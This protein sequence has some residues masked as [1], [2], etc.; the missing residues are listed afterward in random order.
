MLRVLVKRGVNLN[1][2]DNHGEAALSLMSSAGHLLGVKTLLDSTVDVNAGFPLHKALENIVN[3][4][5][6]SSQLFAYKQIALILIDKGA[7]VLLTRPPSDGSSGPGKTALQMVI[8][9]LKSEAPEVRLEG[10]VDV[11]EA[12]VAKL[13]STSE[14]KSEINQVREL[15]AEFEKTF[16]KSSERLKM[17]ACQMAAK[18]NVDSWVGVFPGSGVCYLGPMIGPYTGWLLGPA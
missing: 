14:L 6:G 9:L 13:S 1:L 16:P 3:P 4:L 11:L 2:V 18:V 17:V 5:Y 8:G 7:N 10:F 12:M 15:S